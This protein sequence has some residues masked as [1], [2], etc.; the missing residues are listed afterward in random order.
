[1][2]SWSFVLLF[3]P[4]MVCFAFGFLVFWATKVQ[5]SHYLLVL[6]QMDQLLSQRKTVL[7]FDI[8]S[9]AIDLDQ[10]ADYSMISQEVSI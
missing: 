2:D 7:N 9:I 6:R 4:D 5:T 10:M 1:M 8:R 3:E